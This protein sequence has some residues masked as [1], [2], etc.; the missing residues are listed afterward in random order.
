MKG[1]TMAEQ[2]LHH[3]IE[4]MNYHNDHRVRAGE[5]GDWF[6]TFDEK[7]MTATIAVECCDQARDQLGL[8]HVANC[9]SC[10][11]RGEC[12]GMLMLTVRVVYEVCPTCD[13]K[14][15]HVNPSIDCCGLTAEDFAEDPDFAESYHRGMYDQPCNQCRGRRVVPEPHPD[16]KAALE[17]IEK[18]AIDDAAYHAEC[19]AEIRMGA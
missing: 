5:S 7:A 6:E 19:M 3:I 15:T 10:D 9:E 12:D 14:G 11:M 1:D 8:P 17:Y 16:E 4:D 2:N 18:K 13:G